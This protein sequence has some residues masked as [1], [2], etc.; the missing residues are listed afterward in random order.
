ML[1]AR[2]ANGFEIEASCEARGI[3]DGLR[4][5]FTYRDVTDASRTEVRCSLRGSSPPTLKVT[6]GVTGRRR[7]MAILAEA[8]RGGFTQA[9]HSPAT[10]K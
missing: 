7:I 9:F 1:H 10:S 3:K 4:S 5:R 6:R 8:T 2:K